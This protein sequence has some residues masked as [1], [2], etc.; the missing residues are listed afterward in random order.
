VHEAGRGHI[1]TQL[2]VK[3]LREESPVAN[4]THSSIWLLGS[5]E[6]LEAAIEV[7]ASFGMKSLFPD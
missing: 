6:G 2:P 3:L 5:E 4:T 1:A 7:S